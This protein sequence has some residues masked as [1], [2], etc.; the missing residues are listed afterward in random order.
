MGHWQL[1]DWSTDRRRPRSGPC[2]KSNPSL[3][4]EES[5]TGADQLL[6]EALSRAAASL[7]RSEPTHL[8]E[9]HLKGAVKEALTEL[10]QEGDQPFRVG[11]MEHGLSM[12]GFRGVGTV[13]VAI[14]DSASRPEALVELKWGA[15]TLVNVAWDVV[16]LALA[17]RCGETAR[18]FV[19]AGAPIEQWK[20]KPGRELFEYRNRDVGDLMIVYQDAFDFWRTEVKCQPTRLPA[21]IE[22]R[23]L[24][25]APL[26]I[27]EHAWEI[28]VAE[29]RARG[30]W[31]V[32]FENGREVSRDRGDRFTS[33]LVS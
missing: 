12:S 7:Q 29:I 11:T 10:I 8:L 17:H 2:L 24:G 20:N 5:V 22:T 27:G 33:F 3:C 26:I 4:D 16:K 28:R 18:A 21:E 23:P 13:D 32:N 19:A 31:S 14:Y 25:T 1:T 6:R 9:K 30:E 15:G